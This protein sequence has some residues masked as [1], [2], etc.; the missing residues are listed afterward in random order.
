MPA[1]I[2]ASE[3]SSIPRLSGRPASTT[4]TTPASTAASSLGRVFKAVASSDRKISGTAKSRC[5]DGGAVAPSNAP[6]SAEPVHATNSGSH[7]ASR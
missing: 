5:Q 2:P 1:A 4:A 3:A 7:E 6:A